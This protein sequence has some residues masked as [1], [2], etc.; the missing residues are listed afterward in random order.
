MPSKQQQI[1]PPQFSEDTAQFIE[2]MSHDPLT[3]W[4]W[5]EAL[6]WIVSLPETPE[7]RS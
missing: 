4:A 1:Y 2:D 3:Y 7:A 5:V 6:T